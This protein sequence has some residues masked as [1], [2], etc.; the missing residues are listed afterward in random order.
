MTAHS[1]HPGFNDA[2]SGNGAADAPD[3]CKRPEGKPGVTASGEALVLDR[4]RGSASI[5]RKV[6]RP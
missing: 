4:P 1:T 3:L 5:E 2:R 6:F